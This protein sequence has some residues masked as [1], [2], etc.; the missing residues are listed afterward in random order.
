MIYR[1]SIDYKRFDFSESSTACN[2]AAL[3]KNY[4][5]EKDVKVEIELIAE[6]E[7]DV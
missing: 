2:F 3:A 4:S 7:K 6:D 5:I 1:V